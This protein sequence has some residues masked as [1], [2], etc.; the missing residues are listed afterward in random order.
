MSKRKIAAAV[1]MAI[2]ISVLGV[3]A[4]AGLA[5]LV[6]PFLL[7]NA[8]RSWFLPVV[9]CLLGLST[10]WFVLYRKHVAKR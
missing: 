6:V 2:A 1:L 4:C 9:L 8:D 7:A 3:A 5:E 10:F